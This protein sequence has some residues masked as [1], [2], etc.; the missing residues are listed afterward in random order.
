MSR[1]LVIFLA[2]AGAPALAHLPGAPM[3][4]QRDVRLVQSVYSRGWAEV[5]HPTSECDL[6]TLISFDVLQKNKPQQSY[7]VALTR[8]ACEAR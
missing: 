5:H 7:A 6:P 1:I 3:E 8:A 2:L 4:T